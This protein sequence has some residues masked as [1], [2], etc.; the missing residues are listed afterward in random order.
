MDS[1]S[2]DLP[3]PNY[4]F[5]NTLRT[6][7]TNAILNT[8]LF[9]DPDNTKYDE[10]P[11]M[12]GNNSETNMFCTKNSFNMKLTSYELN[13]NSLHS[14]KIAAQTDLSYPKSN[15]QFEDEANHN[16]NALEVGIRKQYNPQKNCVNLDTYQQQSSSYQ[17]D[18]TQNYDT[19]LLGKN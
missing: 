5:T 15:A 14:N 10:C 17:T 12:S 18:M 11:E 7:K 4:N 9:S 6:F 3:M 2:N 19:D 16:M 13:S 8:N 1:I